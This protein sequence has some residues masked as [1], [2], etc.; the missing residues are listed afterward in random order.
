MSN[1]DQKT[2]TYL[3][4]LDKYQKETDQLS[5]EF[6]EG[7]LQLSKANFGLSSTNTRFGQDM[8]D[9]RMK[10]IAIV[11][12]NKNGEFGLHRETAKSEQQYLQAN[13]LNKTQK[14]TAKKS[15][16]SS[17]RNN[18]D[19]EKS[20]ISTHASDKR[21]AVSKDPIQMFGIIVP[22]SLRTSQTHFINSLDAIVNVINY[23]RKLKQLEDDLN[24]QLPFKHPVNTNNDK[25]NER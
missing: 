3:E 23:E 22:S 4:V 10:R 20:N 6:R 9:E 15:S 2:Q 17:S 21:S 12:I 13:K 19:K 16:D 8:Y 14:G 11:R 1:V 24:K 7:F 18:K 5:N 25:I